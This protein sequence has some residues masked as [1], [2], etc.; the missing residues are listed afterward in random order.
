MHK[1]GQGTPSACYRLLIKAQTTNSD[2]AFR[3]RNSNK[4]LGRE[5]IGACHGL[6]KA[7]HSDW[8]GLVR[9]MEAW[10][11]GAVSGI[12]FLFEFWVHWVFPLVTHG[13]LVLFFLIT[14]GLFSFPPLFVTQRLNLEPLLQS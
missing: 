5:M 10:W 8:L 9:G 3:A 6:S 2:K 12:V 11:G 14:H 4:A 7:S 1:D 13:H